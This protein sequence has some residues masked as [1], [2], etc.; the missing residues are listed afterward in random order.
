MFDV[1]LD[2]SENDSERIACRQGGFVSS[3][4]TFEYKASEN[5]GTRKIP[6]RKFKGTLV[7]WIKKAAFATS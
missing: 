3:I 6:F 7:S 5:F 4:A 1:V 2:A